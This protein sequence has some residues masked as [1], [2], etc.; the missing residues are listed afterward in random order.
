M[1][2]IGE[3]ACLSRGIDGRRVEYYRLRSNKFNFY[4]FS[5]NHAHEIWVS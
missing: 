3:F 5:L 4:Q 2:G 1:K